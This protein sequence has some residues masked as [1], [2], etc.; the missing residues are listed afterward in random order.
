[1]Y[2]H[3]QAISFI[4]L[5]DHILNNRTKYHVI[6]QFGPLYKMAR[7]FSSWVCEIH[8]IT[9]S[10]SMGGPLTAWYIKYDVKTKPH[11]QT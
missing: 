4:L 8:I 1:M 6:G 5:N 11:M 10:Y 3:L 2:K 7:F 9:I